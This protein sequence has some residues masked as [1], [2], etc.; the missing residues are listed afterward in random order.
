MLDSVTDA[1]RHIGGTRIE[2]GLSMTSRVIAVAPFVLTVFG[3]TGDLAGR[4]LLPALFRRDFAGQLPDEATIFGVARGAMS[5]DDF[6]AIVRAA[7]MKY[8]PASETAG[9]ELDRFLA[10]IT[11]IAADAE[12][13]NG[14]TELAAALSAYAGRIQVHYLATAPHLFGPICERLGHYGLSKGDSRIVIEKPIGKDLESQS[15]SIKPSA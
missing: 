14:W 6:L 5:Q 13:E 2:K 7:I 9:P 10:R 3:A 11:Y 15:G 1:T 12:G 4:K 8:A